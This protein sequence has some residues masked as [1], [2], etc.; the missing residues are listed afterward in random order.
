[1][2]QFTC[3]FRLLLPSYALDFPAAGPG[4]GKVLDRLTFHLTE[5][6]GCITTVVRRRVGEVS[7]SGVLVD[8]SKEALHILFK[9][10]IRLYIFTEITSENCLH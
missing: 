4:T 9:N 6:T 8:V 1:M 3:R 10:R 2:Y 7:M 5:A